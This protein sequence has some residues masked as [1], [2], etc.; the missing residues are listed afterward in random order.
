MTGP[1]LIRGEALSPGAESQTPGELL[2]QARIAYYDKGDDKACARH[3]WEATFRSIQQLAAQM[4]H[5]CE[6]RDQADRFTWFLEHDQGG[7]RLHA[8]GMLDFGLGM[9]EHAEE[10][11][12][13]QDP[14]F[15]WTFQEF[16]LAI[17]EVTRIAQSL[18]AFAKTLQ[19]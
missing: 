12:L 2:R 8:T 7:K 10:S 15:A 14:E 1:D 16:P 3:L 19:S 11:G 13:S 18:S 17:K 5:P 6:D 9:L 4:G